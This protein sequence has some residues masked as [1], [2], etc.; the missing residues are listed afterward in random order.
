ML[1]TH[2]DLEEKQRILVRT[3]LKS[4]FE[5]GECRTYDADNVLMIITNTGMA[6]R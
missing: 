5:N 4:F 2:A 3:F 6:S 1:S